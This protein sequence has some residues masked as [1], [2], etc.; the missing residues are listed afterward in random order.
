MAVYLK[1]G[2]RPLNVITCSDIDMMNTKADGRLVHKDGTPYGG[3][4][5]D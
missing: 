4:Q 1:V 2:R 3:S 5:S